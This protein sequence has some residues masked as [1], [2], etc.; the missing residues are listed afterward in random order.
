MKKL[1]ALLLAVA[2]VFAVASCGKKGGDDTTPAADT[3]NQTAAYVRPTTYARADEGE[4]YENALGAFEAMVTAAKNAATVNERYVLFAKAEAFLLDAAVMLPTTTQGGAYTINRIAPH[5]VPYVQWGNDDDRVKS[6]VIAN[7]FITKEDRAALLEEWGKA[8]AGEGTYDP[9]AWLTAHGYTLNNAYKTTFATKPATIDWLNTSEQADTEI[10][11]NCVDGLV[12][13]NNLNQMLPALAT[14]WNVSDD[15]LTYTFTIRQGVKWY[16]AEGQEYATLT[17]ADFEA[18]FQH[19]LDAKAGL[20]ELIFGIVKGAKEYVKD[21]GAWA[22][23]GYKATGDY[24]LTVT[25]E[26]PTSYF[27]TMLSYSIFLPICKTFYESRG[28]VFGIEAYATA[29]QDTTSYTY[30]LNTDPSSQ[31]Y[32]G[33]FRLTKMNDSEIVCTKNPNYY[34]VDKVTLSSITWIYDAGEDPLATY[35]DVISNVYP[36]TGLSEASGTLAK[37]KNDKVPGD[38]DNK[39]YFEKYAYVSDT[40]STTYLGG[41]NLDRGTFALA[42]GNVASAKTED[43]K[44]DTWLAMQNKSFRQA[45]IYAFDKGAWNAVTRGSD[46]KYTN[47]RNMYTHPEFV[48]L[49]ADTTVDGKTFKAGTFYGEMVQYYLEQ[50]GSPVIVADGQD[51]WY[52]P[53]E[54]RRALEKAKTELAA[55]GVTLPIQIDLVYYSASPNNTAQAQAFKKGIEDN[56]G[57]ENVVI[58]LVEATTSQ[59]YYSSGY[60]AKT[61]IALNCDLCYGTGWGPDFGDPSTYLDTFLGYG[62]GYMAKLLGVF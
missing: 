52:H 56:L 51:G 17:A 25:L 35:A 26:Q 15:G 31:V 19:M 20:E 10:T 38:A 27:L 33:P 24:T 4:V 37:A 29:S 16:T 2:M 53:S 11:V 12:E 32:C 47:L 46:L 45:L 30:G 40:T 18:G 50:L 6:L 22:N 13:Y 57:K 43:Q 61:G 62:A 55:Y 49:T 41:L 1:L 44:I 36:G 54:A 7:E 9:A 3:G 39:T 8:C 58:N 14:A 5:T 28:G 21:G 60:R 59:D 23:V 48:S 42:S 34:N